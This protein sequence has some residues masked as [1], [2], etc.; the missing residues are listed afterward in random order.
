MTELIP[1]AQPEALDKLAEDLKEVA[2]Q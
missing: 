2:N 1:P